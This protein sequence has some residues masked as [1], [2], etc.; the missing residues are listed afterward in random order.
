VAVPAAEQAAFQE[1]LGTLAGLPKR[2]ASPADGPAPPDPAPVAVPVERPLSAAVLAEASERLAVYI[3]P[4]A[5]FL[6]KRAAAQASGTRDLYERLARHI[7]DPA[8]RRR[9]AAATEELAEP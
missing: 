3:G 6:V 1:R 9:F 2:G 4:M 8:D 7:D 5:K